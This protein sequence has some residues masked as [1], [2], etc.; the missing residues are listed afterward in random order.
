M[1]S[2]AALLPMSAIITFKATGAL[3]IRSASGTNNVQWVLTEESVS[4]QLCEI[5]LC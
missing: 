1:V 2:V 5:R 4:A 3:V